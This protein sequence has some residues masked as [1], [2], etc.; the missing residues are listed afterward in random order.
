[1]VVRGL[2]VIRDDTFMLEIWNEGHWLKEI[3][4]STISMVEWYVE[5]PNLVGLCF[6]SC[7]SCLYYVL[8]PKPVGCIEAKCLTKFQSRLGMLRPSPKGDFLLISIVIMFLMNSR[9]YNKFLVEA[10]ILG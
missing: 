5:V 1:L 4:G 8:Y 7:F 9:S 2:F 10:R 3:F 6:I